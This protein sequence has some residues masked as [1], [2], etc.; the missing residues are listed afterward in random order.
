MAAILDLTI[1]QGSTYSHTLELRQGNPSGS[2]LNLTG[3]TAKMQVRLSVNN[4]DV[5][6]ELSTMNGGLTIDGINGKITIQI[7]PEQ[8]RL[9]VYGKMVYDLE[10]SISG[11]DTRIVQGS[12]VCSLEVTR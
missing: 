6:L 3:Y 9:F 8:S 11:N 1:D 2:V 7:T 10:I 4:P 12:I 5:I